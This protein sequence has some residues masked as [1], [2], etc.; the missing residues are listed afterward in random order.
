[1]NK[2]T[3]NKYIFLCFLL[4]FLL[5]GCS[6]NNTPISKTGFYFD[7]V[8]QITLYDTRDE[9]LL[10]GCFQ[11]AQTYENLFSAT[12]RDSDIWN[13]NHAQGKSICVSDDTVHLLKSAIYYS[14]LTEGKIDPTIYP[15]SRLWNFGSGDTAMVPESTLLTSALTHVDYRNIDFSETNPHEISLKDPD[16]AIDLGFIAKGYIA[17]QMK[18]Y[19]QN[20][21]VHS[22]CINLGG[23]VLTIGNKPDES[24]FRIGIQ[25]PFAKSG[26]AITVV[27]VENYSLVSSGIYE[28]YFYENNIL[29]HHI[30]DSHTGYPVDNNL[31]GVTILSPSSEEGDA[32]S[33]TCFIL[34]L[35]DGMHLIEEIPGIEALFITKDDKL[36]YSSG[37]PQT[38]P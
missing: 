24:P 34:G 1:M 27:P 13:I 15:V 5:C 31:A 19:L 38:G 16:S 21:H 33:T 4:I 8:I 6:Q 14:E 22:A 20:N 11:I 35:E 28:R 32:L 29:Y 3:H 23:N 2:K 17:D 36:Y 26:E 10:D 12:K 25:K 37:F 30:L 18:E 7:T 9:Q